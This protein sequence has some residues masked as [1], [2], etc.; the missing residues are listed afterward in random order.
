MLWGMAGEFNPMT[1]FDFSFDNTSMMMAAMA[2]IFVFGLRQVVDYIP[3]KPFHDVAVETRVYVLNM[4]GTSA[5][6]VKAAIIASLLS[7]FAGL[8][9]EFLFRGVLFTLLEGFL[10]MVPAF[11]VSSLCYGFV[12]Q[13]TPL[14]GANAFIETVAGIMFA[15]I[16][17]IS[18]HNL[19]VPIAA[20]TVY[21]FATIMV[22]WWLATSQLQAS[23]KS[24]LHIIPE[25][26]HYY[27]ALAKAVFDTIDNDH[28]GAIDVRDLEIGM[29]HFGIHSMGKKNEIPQE[30]FNQLDYDHDGRVSLNEFA[31]LLQDGVYEATMPM[32]K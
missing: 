9:E 1:I 13:N 7:G 24:Q 32:K 29:K 15:Y 4:I 14:Y 30:V 3:A 26:D 2:A 20:H 16:Y 12:H 17:V 19:A 10:G 28:D 5:S 6:P 22:T 11:V 23:E 8:S 31:S 25:K 18:G 27:R 21:D